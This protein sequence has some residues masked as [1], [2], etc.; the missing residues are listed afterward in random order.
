MELP[1]RA[2]LGLLLVIGCAVAGA[3]SKPMGGEQAQGYLEF[4]EQQDM[5]CYNL[6]PGGQLR[7][8]KS[9]HPSHRIRFRLVRYFAAIKQ[10]G[11]AEGTL[12]PA[13]SLAL[14]CTRVDGR[15][16]RWEIHT[17]HFIN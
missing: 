14:G 15:E 5:R 13:G 2:L 4:L 3:E 17:A 8:L 6:S 10:P 16:Q 7:L 12:E 9:S 1:T 11:F